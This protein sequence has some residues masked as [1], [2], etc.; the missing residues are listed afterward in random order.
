MS[1]QTGF[2]L[3]PDRAVIAIRVNGQLMDKA[4]T[5]TETDT[6]E[7]VEV[8]SPDGLN[9]L[10]HSS[11]HVLAQAV[12]RINPEAKLGI[13]PP[14][15]DGFYYDF[16]VAEHFTPDDLGAISKEMERIIRSGQRFVRRAGSDDEA[17][18]EL[19]AEPY[20]LELIGLKGAAESGTDGESVEVG[21]GEL[22]IYDNV[23][24]DS[25]VDWKDL[26]R[27]PHVP[28][29]GALG[30]FKLMRVAASMR[31]T[32]LERKANPQNDILS[33]LWKIEVDGKPTTLEDMENYGVLLFIAGLDTVINGM[34]LGVRHLAQHPELQAEMRKNPAMIADVTEEML[35]R[36][37][38]T[39]P[40]RIMAKDVEF[41]GV[42]LKKGD[43]VM[44]YLPAA[45][46]DAKEYA[47][48]DQFDLARAGTPHIAFNAG[49]HR[50]LGSHLA[51]V[52]LQVLY[53][54]M[55]KGLPEFRLDPANPPTFHG[56]HVVGVHTVNLLWDV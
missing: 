34:G 15:Q 7:P 30:Q 33:M 42:Q 1:A 49:P 38:F 46:L 35:R 27:G 43:K 22:T 18:A 50:C 28:N 32:M 39:V 54:E 55:M 9:I 20:K 19:A 6:V 52:E 14:V 29:T 44:L 41:M 21:A 53:E 25:N 26:C 31:D 36:Y 48:P 51:R 12:Q 45:D 16:D 40:P 56:G 37:T 3:F 11:A 8:D 2:D 47:N 10:R 4:A 5:V 17:R 13:G 24:R 23:D